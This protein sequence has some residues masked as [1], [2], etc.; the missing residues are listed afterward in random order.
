MNHN[1]G[2]CLTV[3]GGRAVLRM[4]GII[5]W[6]ASLRRM[7]QRTRMTQP[8]R[9]AGLWSALAVAT[10]WRLSI[11]GAVEE[12]IPE[13]TRLDVADALAGPRRQRRATRLRLVSTFRRGWIVI[14]VAWLE[15][16]LLPLD[17]FVSEPWPAIAP[18]DR[19]TMAPAW[20]VA[21]VAA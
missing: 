18:L 16:Q 3:L 13:S 4:M 21:H 7:W 17:G 2:K 9:A 12:T 1:R 11:G 5:G 10:L 14:L 20:R 8:D 19:Y 6:L 15:Q